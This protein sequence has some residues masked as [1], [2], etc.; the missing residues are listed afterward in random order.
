MFF[1]VSNIGLDAFNRQFLPT[2]P[3]RLGENVSPTHSPPIGITPST[4]QTG[5]STT[6]SQ[7]QPA[8]SL[9]AGLIRPQPQLPQNAA[10]S[11]MVA[12]V[13]AANSQVTNGSPITAQALLHHHLNQQQQ[14]QQQSTQISPLRI[15][16]N[17]PTRINSTSSSTSQA[18]SDHVI[19]TTSSSSPT[20]PGVTTL[21]H[22]LHIFNG[23]HLARMSQLSQLHRP[24]ESPSPTPPQTNVA[25]SRTGTKES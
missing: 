20:V 3:Y 19:T 5:T 21:K 16:I 4:S 25:H 14:Q 12:A 15:R 23:S 1:K 24:F 8:Y 7:S 10:I 13:C 6:L 18:S 2:M 11:A 22:P 17:S 9:P